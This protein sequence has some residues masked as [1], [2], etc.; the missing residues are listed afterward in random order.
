M[1]TL[2]DEILTE[3][4]EDMAE[5]GDSMRSDWSESISGWQE[6]GPAGDYPTRPGAN[7]RLST[8]T[9]QI[10]VCACECVD[11][12]SRVS[13]RRDE[14]ESKRFSMQTLQLA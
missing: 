13:A 5:E 9:Q 14:K 8:V 1:E 4:I 2:R 6:T 11:A 12:A 10:A 7:Y 3:T